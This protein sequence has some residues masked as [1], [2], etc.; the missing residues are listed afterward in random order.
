MKKV[1]AI[2]MSSAVTWCGQGDLNP[3]ALRHRNLNPA[4]LPIP[5]CPQR[6]GLRTAP[7]YHRGAELS[8]V[9]PFGKGL[10]QIP[11]HASVHPVPQE[12]GR[13]LQLLHRNDLQKIQM[14][15][16]PAQPD[17][18]VKNRFAAPNRAHHNGN[19]RLLGNLETRRCSPGP[20][21]EAPRILKWF[22]GLPGRFHGSEADKGSGAS[23]YSPQTSGHFPASK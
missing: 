20:A 16:R 3:H 23:A 12:L 6:I 1:A 10:S 22:S 17:R 7:S 19:L 21:G 9:V 2:D 14:H 18:P 11:S 15:M 5:S 13:T 8:T 4:R